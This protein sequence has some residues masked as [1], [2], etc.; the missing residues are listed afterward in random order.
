MICTAADFCQVDVVKFQKRDIETSLSIPQRNAPHPE[1]HHAYGATYGAHRQALEF[2]LDKHRR[3]K[4]LC[5][6]FGVVYSC[7]V[8]D[9][10]SARGI[11]SLC[12]AMIK[13]P[14]AQNLNWN[15]LQ[16]LTSEYG[17]E[18]HV[19]LGMTTRA[20]EQKLIAFLQKSGRISEVVLY[21]C[22]SA[23]PVED[24]DI[25]LPEILRLRETYG[26]MIRSVGFSGHHLGISPDNVAVAFGAEWIERHF[27]LNRAW[28]GTDHAASL[29]PDDL[30]R[31]CCDLRKIPN[32][33]RNK[34]E[35]IVDAERPQ[36]AK[37]KAFD[38]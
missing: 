3:L 32:M 9:V 11:A 26:S 5:D 33:M 19:S 18:I 23:Y 8:W 6:A 30:R 21:A 17:G 22:T 29:E 24:E 34:P 20:E 25:Y 7:T 16:V 36:R 31:M 38:A 35:S 10:V 37:L 2:D 4:D 1:P 28:K 13:V 15:L 12:P 27:T 14:S